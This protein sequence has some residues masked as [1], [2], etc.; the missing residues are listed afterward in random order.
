MLIVCLICL[1][2]IRMIV[3]SISFLNTKSR[4]LS[5]YPLIESEFEI[6]IEFDLVT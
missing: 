6:E 2:V 3:H 1:I 4:I 5:I